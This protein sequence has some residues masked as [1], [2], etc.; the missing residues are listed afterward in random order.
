MY[1]VNAKEKK[2]VEIDEESENQ[3]WISYKSFTD[4]SLQDFG[5]KSIPAKHSSCSGLWPK[6][7]ETTPERCKPQMKQQQQQMPC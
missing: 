7:N 3:A 2:L 1:F 6:N 4:Q 5:M